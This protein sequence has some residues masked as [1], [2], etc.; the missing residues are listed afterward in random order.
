MCELT[1]TAMASAAELA[2]QRTGPTKASRAAMRSPHAALDAFQ[3]R[4]TVRGG[5]RKAHD[6]P[7]SGSHIHIK[8]AFSRCN[9]ST[10][11]KRFAWSSHRVETTSPGSKPGSTHKSKT[12]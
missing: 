5:A 2:V 7:S 4:S 9:G 3:L 12:L 8:V 10:V 11:L 1:V 6:L